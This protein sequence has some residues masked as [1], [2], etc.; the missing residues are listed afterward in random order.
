MIIFFLSVRLI[1]DSIKKIK[2][3]E[4]YVDAN[5]SRSYLFTI[6]QKKYYL[7]PYIYIKLRVNFIYLENEYIELN[8]IYN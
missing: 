8:A 4:F 1:D 5:S 3:E 7:L 2:D 6:L